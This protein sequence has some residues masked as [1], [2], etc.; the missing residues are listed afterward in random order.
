V[1]AALTT[2]QSLD[3]HGR[4][5]VDEDAHVVCLPRLSG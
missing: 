4:V 1:E 3:H 2:G 5:L